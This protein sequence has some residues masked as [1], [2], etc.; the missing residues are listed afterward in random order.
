MEILDHLFGKDDHLSTLQMATRAIIVFLSALIILRIASTRTFGKETT[1]DNIVVIMLGGILSR[2]ITGA[3]PFIPVMAATL[4][5]IIMH[6][7]LALLCLHSHALGN[8][9]KGKK[10]ILFEQGR[11][12][13]SM[14]K[15]TLLSEEDI[16]Q[17]TR[18]AVNEEDWSKVEKIVMER[19]GTLT[20]IKKTGDS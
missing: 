15:K 4:S 3:S 18:E 8:L 13:H 6:Q 7:F 19:N 11:L 5:I 16:K 20:A 9:I 12:N 17:G 10:K 14:M 1:I 2:V